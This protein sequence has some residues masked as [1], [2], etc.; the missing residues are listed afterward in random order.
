MYK[1]RVRAWSATHETGD[2]PSLAVEI[3]VLGLVPVLKLILFGILLATV[4]QEAQAALL[5]ESC[6]KHKS[7][8][9]QSYQ[10]LRVCRVVFT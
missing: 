5:G 2:C 1:V 6:S 7:N 4:W 3:C 8:T 10:G 9:V